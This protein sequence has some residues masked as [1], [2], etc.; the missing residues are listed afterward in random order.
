ME[1][2]VTGAGSDADARVVAKVRARMRA[3]PCVHTSAAV[4]YRL[5]PCG[6]ACIH[7]LHGT[8][9][10]LQHSMHTALHGLKSSVL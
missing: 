8:A 3:C 7:C 6:T 4:V 1:I 9:S 2:L 10:C 5:L